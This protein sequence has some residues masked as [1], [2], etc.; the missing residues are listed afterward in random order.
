MTLV[1]DN[2]SAH[3]PAAFH[4]VFEPARAHALLQRVEFVFTLKHGSWLN[5]AEIEFA[6]L[7]THG[8]L[9]RVPEC[10]P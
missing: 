5:M 3:Q 7:L 2:L 8:L 9:N 10:Q 4:E 6:A 1:L